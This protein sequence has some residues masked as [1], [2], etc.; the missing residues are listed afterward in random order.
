[1]PSNDQDIID[2]IVDNS[3][4]FN[5]AELRLKFK[6]QKVKLYNLVR[7]NK[8]SDHIIKIRNALPTQKIPKN[9][10]YF[11]NR[12][13]FADTEQE[14]ITAIKN[15]EKNV[16]IQKRFLIRYSLIKVIIQKHHLESYQ[17]RDADSIITKK[18]I[19]L[20][21]AHPNQ[22]D[23]FQIGKQLG[24]DGSKV[25]RIAKVAKIIDLIKSHKLTDREAKLAKLNSITFKTRIE[26]I[27]KA[28][29]CG[30]TDQMIAD[31]LGIYKQRVN[32]LRLSNNLKKQESCKPSINPTR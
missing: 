19:K 16:S 18:I 26:L 10:H 31:K 1:M 4:K 17:K 11:K 3:K 12:P 5:Y 32:Q 28:H 27:Q 8:I 2:Y 25:T 22:L 14:I 9:L 23:K 13:G 20:L 7:K 30:I 15:G 29:N 6:I 21:Y 24:I